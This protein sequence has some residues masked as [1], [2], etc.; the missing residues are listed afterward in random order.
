MLPVLIRR[1]G[2]PQAGS[3]A[4][5]SVKLEP[6]RATPPSLGQWIEALVR[7]IALPIFCLCLGFWEA[8]IRPMNPLAWLLLALLL[9]SPERPALPT[10][11]R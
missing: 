6:A 11:D 4:R 5:V 9:A 2:G 1:A 8:A 7:E 3:E 10:G